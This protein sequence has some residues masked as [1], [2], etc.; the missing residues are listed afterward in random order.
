MKIHYVYDLALKDALKDLRVAR[1]FL[2][3][4]LPDLVR[5]QVDL[6]TLVLCNGSFSVPGLRKLDRDVLFSAEFKP[7]PFHADKKKERAFFYLHW[8]N[9]PDPDP[10]IAWRMIE[11]MVPIITSHLKLTGSQ[12]LP[13]V[14]PLVLCSGHQAYPYSVEVFDLFGEHQALA[15]AWMFNRFKLIDLNVIPDEAIRTHPWS[16]LLEMMFKHIRSKTILKFLDTL[17]LEFQN[18][19]QAGA[20]EY[21]LTLLTTLLSKAE[22][23]DK[24]AF[25]NWVSHHLPKHLEEPLLTIAEQLIQEGVRQGK[26]KGKQEG[27][28]EA[29]IEIVKQTGHFELASI[30]TQLPI[31][32]IK[33]L[34]EN[35]GQV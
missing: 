9:K 7:G 29:A 19:V 30:V 2:A 33:R 5:S 23:K 26:H 11:Y 21:A 15:K 12:V 17:S 13:I 16:C 32:K 1:D 35:A 8:E 27:K 20:N 14:I 18:M 34:M 24:T 28:Q 25:F 3:H 31:D 6:S 4:Y 22:I 10:L